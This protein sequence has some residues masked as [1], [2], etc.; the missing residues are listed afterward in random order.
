MLLLCLTFEV[1]AQYNLLR[2]GEP[3]TYD[4]AVNIEISE[5]RK[6]RRKVLT[7]DSLVAQLNQE[8]EIRQG[9]GRAFAS[10]V[11]IMQNII[12]RQTETIKSKDETIRQLSQS[13]DNLAHATK[14][15]QIFKNP[16]ADVG[17]KILIGAVIT[18]GVNQL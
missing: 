17:A 9:Q 6:I 8:I 3:S 15:I 1:S 13:F 18:W 12:D 4:S 16:L 7:A 5:Y 11:N 2:R 10:K 14:K